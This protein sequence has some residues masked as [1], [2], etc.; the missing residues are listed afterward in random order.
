MRILV[1]N[2]YLAVITYWIYLV[3]LLVFAV[4]NIVKSASFA[5]FQGSHTFPCQSLLLSTSVLDDTHIYTS[6]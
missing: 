2:R 6:A 5:S 3:S 1:L 4:N